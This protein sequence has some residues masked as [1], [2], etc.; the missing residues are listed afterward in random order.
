VLAAGAVEVV[1]L[2]LGVQVPY[3]LL[4]TVFFA[5][6]ALRRAVGRV[7]A[8]RVPLAMT[9]AAPAI[10]GIDPDGLSDGLRLAVGRWD[11]RLAWTE[12]DPPRFASAVRPR[13]AEIADERL[14]QRHG[15]TRA[16]DPGR[17]RE[18]MGERLWTFLSAPLSR[19]PNPRDLAA[20]VDDMEKL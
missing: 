4:V 15:V 13:L 18:I 9:P 5:L 6:L 11:T 17:A 8:E 20:V 3:L 16:S 12:R 19:S 2:P 14:R 1:L 7:A 10:D